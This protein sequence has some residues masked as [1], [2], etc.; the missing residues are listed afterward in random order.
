MGELDEIARRAWR[1]TI[2]I[3]IGGIV[4][5]A[6]IG[7]LLPGTD[8]A[9]GRF[10]SVVGFGL[11]VGG[12]SGACSLLTASFRLAPSLQWPLQGL[13][14][15]D[16]RGVR[17]AVFSGRPIEPRDSELAR[18]AFDWAYGAAATLPVS[19]GQF[20]LLYAG[21]AGPQVPNLIRDDA[22]N[23][24]FPRVFIAA[25]VVVAIVFSVVFGRQIRGARR[26]LA[27]TNER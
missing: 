26:Y 12:L 8:S 15:A 25:L 5:G 23:P 1:R 9:L 3:A 24:E 19:L 16:R 14:R 22:W 7:A 17:R 21:I 2:P 20:L 27:A 11:C 6:V 13:G 4:V 10:L 18:R